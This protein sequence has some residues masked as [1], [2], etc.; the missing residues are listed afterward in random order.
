MASASKLDPVSTKCQRIAMLA[1]QNPQMGFTSLA[2]LIDMDWLREAVRRTRKDGAAGTLNFSVRCVPYCLPENDNFSDATSAYIDA[3]VSSTTLMTSTEHATLEA[4]EPSP[5][6]NIGATVWY[7]VVPQTKSD[8]TIDTAGSDFDTVLAVYG[9]PSEIYPSPPGTLTASQC[10]NDAIG[11]QSRLTVHTTG[12][13]APIYVQV[14]GADGATGALVLN[15]A[16]DPACAPAN[17]DIINAWGAGAPWS[18]M[19]QTDAATTEPGEPR[20]CGNIG[21]TVWYMVGMGVNATLAVDTGG[22]TFDTVVA[23]YTVNAGPSGYTPARNIGCSVSSATTKARAEFAAEA[24]QTYL[25]QLGG[26]DGAAGELNVSIMCT[27]AACPPPGD[28]MEDAQILGGD[29][30]LEIDT[31]GATVEPGETLNCG[32]VGAT[33]WYHVQ[34]AATLRIRLSAVDSNYPVAFAAYRWTTLSPPG[35]VAFAGC[36]DP[37]Q[38]STIELGP[39][40]VFL[41]Y[42]VQIGS[43]SGKGGALRLRAECISGGPCAHGDQLP[44]T[45]SP[46]PITDAL[47]SGS[48]IIAGPDTGSGGYLPGAR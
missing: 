6:G 7:Q 38:P 36:G 41:E 11:R 4:G 32:I 40:P 44:T 25:V 47:G 23:V 9:L 26:R 21:R 28:S 27:P 34:A 10:N 20:P 45:D 24:N 16:C 8:I 12:A 13:Y 5:C 48:G 42:L 2:Y 29:T 43:T 35:G 19:T 39:D 46:E 3:R 22:S 33:V 31:S 30:T 1:R 15:V 14:G 17:D 37:A 18:D